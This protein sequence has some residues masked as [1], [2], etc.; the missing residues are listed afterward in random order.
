MSKHS[1]RY[2]SLKEKVKLG[3]EH[4]LD[5]A[6]G[7]IKDQG[8]LKFDSGVELHVRTGIDVKQSDQHIRG[9]VSLPHGTGKKQKI[10]AITADPDKAKSAGAEL[11]G[12][13]E[14][15]KEIQ[16]GKMDFDILVAEPEFMPKLAPVAK[17]LGPRGLMPSPKNGTVSPDVTKAIEELAKGKIAFKNDNTGNIHMLVGRVSFDENQLK[18]NITMAFDAIKTSRPSG[19]KGAFIQ[20]TVLAASMGPG[21]KV[22]L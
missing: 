16:A 15:I 5:E 1:K 9:T 17:I 11:A 6:I 19:V 18:E 10:A 8:E 2:K 13:E 20:N 7:L 12:G 3:K 21:I 22:S 4:G 14:I